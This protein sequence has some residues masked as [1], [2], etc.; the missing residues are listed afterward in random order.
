MRKCLHWLGSLI[1]LLFFI[2][3]FPSFVYAKTFSSEFTEFELPS[4]WDCALEGTEWVCQS[5]NKDRRKEAVIILAAKYVDERDSIAEYQAYLSLPKKFNLPAG[6]IQISEAKTVTVRTID[7]HPWVDALHLASEVSGFYT[8]YLGT[9]KENLGIV[10]SFSVAK[11]HYDAYLDIFERAISTL[12]VFN[13]DNKHSGDRW[14]K[15]EGENSV[16]P[17]VVE[18]NLPSTKLASEVESEIVQ[19]HAPNSREGDSSKT[20]F[21]IGVIVAVVFVLMKSKK[22]K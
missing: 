2:L 20:I 11:D 10:I 1:T 15:Q 5:D 9:V 7:N 22:K 12:K 21:L 4:G 16:D 3:S 18:T 13:Q 17:A 6:K 8:R 14:K 19:K